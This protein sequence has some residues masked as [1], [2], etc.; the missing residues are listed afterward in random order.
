M[1]SSEYNKISPNTLISADAVTGTSVYN[2]KGDKLGEVDDV[3]IDK[4]SGRAVY[5]IMS[6]GGV[7]GL[8]EKHHPLPWST[9]KYDTG[10]GGYVVNLDKDNLTDAPSYA[11]GDRFEWTPDY[12]RSVDKYYNVPT[13]W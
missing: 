10:R 7:L 3:M 12:G 11:R 5:A 13:F 4:I 2:P 9:L 8:G 1:A 6:F